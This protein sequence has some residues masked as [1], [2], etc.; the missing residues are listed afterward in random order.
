MDIQ[1][2]RAFSYM[3]RGAFSELNCDT[4]FEDGVTV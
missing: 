4:F 3:L 1:W 2:L